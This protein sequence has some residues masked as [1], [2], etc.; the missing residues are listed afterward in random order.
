[1]ASYTDVSWMQALFSKKP[2][3]FKQ[4]LLL[5]IPAL[6][7]GLIFRALFVFAI[8][9]GFFPV[10][11]HS[12]FEFSNKLDSEGIFYLSEKRRWFYPIFL[13][14]ASLFPV[15]PWYSVP[16]AQHIL[17]L[18]SVLGI[19]WGCAQV[20]QYPRPIVV[21]VMLI[22]SLWPRT[23]WYEHVLTAESLQLTTFIIV[24]SLLLTTNITKSTYGLSILTLASTLL[25]GMKGSSRFLWLGCFISLFLIHRDPR[26]WAWSKLSYFFTALSFFF[27]GTVGKNSQ[28]DWLALSSSLPLVRLSGEPYSAYRD[29]LGKQIIESREYGSQ[30][31]WKIGTYKKRLNNKD[32]ETT[33]NTNWA[34]LIRKKSLYQSVMRAFWTDAVLM[35][36]I[37][38]FR[39]TL[40]KIQIA[41]SRFPRAEM[42]LPSSYWRVHQRAINKHRLS[43]KLSAHDYFNARLKIPFNLSYAQYNN[44]ALQGSK[45]KFQLYPLISWFDKNL[46][47]MGRSTNTTS[48]S[49]GTKEKFP[50][51]YLKAMGYFSILGTISGLLCSPKRLKILALLIPS[52]LYLAG[53]F[54]VGDALSRYLQPVEW[55]G[56]ILAGVFFD[57][58]IFLYFRCIQGE[59]QLKP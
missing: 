18:I 42:Y 37:Q 53:S 13:Y 24:L 39:F 51:L 40:L 4:L 3:C 6:T 19:G 15:A 29:N 59:K 36:P 41:A 10:D 38:M 23:V 28:G 14:F 54:T 34:E 52:C 57:V 17:G 2:I 46:G 1:M 20:V 50:S 32:Y 7:I 5:A 56:F 11:S 31:P 44:I 9:E 45:K 26:Q 43:K 49:P 55:I 48:S 16:I 21:L 12:Y 27:I 47:W 8:P 35:R 25:A 58:I 33:F 30:Y 22:A